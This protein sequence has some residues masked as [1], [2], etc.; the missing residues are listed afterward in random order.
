MSIQMNIFTIKT[1]LVLASFL[2]LQACNQAFVT[3][4]PPLEPQP[5]PTTAADTDNQLTPP[6]DKYLFMEIML[7]FDGTGTLPM[8]FVDFPGYEYDSSS[9]ML[10]SHGRGEEIS[11]TPA[12]WGFIGIG[13][14][15]SGDMGGGTASQL[16]TIDQLPFTVSAPIFDGKLGEYAEEISY[17]PVTLLTISI[18]GDVLVDIDGQQLMLPVG[19]KWEQMQ[20]MTVSTERFDGNLFAAFSIINHGWNARDLIEIR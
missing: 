5:V 1:V 4:V 13:Q 20:E 2:L 18:N 8:K 7:E 3:D 19:E 16:T 6:N 14:K 17:I 11:L 10:K 12:D 15:R 9:G